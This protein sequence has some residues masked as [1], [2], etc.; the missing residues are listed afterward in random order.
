MISIS[1]HVFIQIIFNELNQLD[2]SVMDSI[3][4]RFE[5]IA[6]S[7]GVTQKWD[8]SYWNSLGASF[9]FNIW[10][11]LLSRHAVLR[12]MMIIDPK[13]FIIIVGSSHIPLTNRG[14][15]FQPNLPLQIKAEVFIPTSPSKLVLRDVLIIF[16][17]NHSI[18]GESVACFFTRWYWFH[19]RCNGPWGGNTDKYT[20][21]LQLLGDSCS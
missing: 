1:S 6:P 21:V 12:L 3:G 9:C 2:T 10:V 17:S 20:V 14:R 16:L 7:H 13:I 5:G 19:L 4:E 15:D 8:F 11:R 18:A